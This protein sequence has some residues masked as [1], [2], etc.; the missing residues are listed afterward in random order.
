MFWRGFKPRLAWIIGFVT[1]TLVI[2][3]S[4]VVILDSTWAEQ[5][6]T[7]RNKPAGFARHIALANEPQFRATIQLVGE[8]AGASGTWIGNDARH[9]Y[10]LTA[11][12]NFTKGGKAT[13]YAYVATDGTTYQGVRLIVH[14]DWNGDNDTRTGYDF[15]I[16]VLDRPVRGVGQ[17]AVLYAGCDEMD[18]LCTMVGYGMRG[19]GSSGELAEY[20]DEDNPKAAAQNL[21]ENVTP[22][23]SPLPKGEDGGNYLGIDFD[24]EDGSATNTYGEPTP[25]NEYEGALGSGDSGGSCWMQYEGQWCVIGVNANGNTSK[26]GAVSYFARVSGQVDWIMSVFPGAKFIGG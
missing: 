6:G 4:G 2:P 22:A 16:V 23:V 17:P 12:H 14:P 18:Q 5:G 10:V 24:K 19:T 1:G 15:A 20:Y 3:A 7:A 25:V 8:S 26:Y 11:G 21:I 13:E 9:G